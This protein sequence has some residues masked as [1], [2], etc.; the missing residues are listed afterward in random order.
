MRK[1]LVLGLLLL[2]F[3]VH[4]QVTVDNFENTSNNWVAVSCAAEIR[5]NEQ[6]TGLNLSNKVLFAL[7]APGCDNWSGAMLKPC[8]QKGYKYLHAYMYRSNANKP[9]LKVSDTNAKDMEPMTQIVANEWQDVVWDISAYE[10]SGIEFVFFMVDRTDI[11]EDAWMLIDEV[12]LSN[13][14]TPRTAVV[15]G[16]DEP[17]VVNPTGDYQLV[18]QDEFEGTAIDKDMWNIEVDGKGGGNNELQYYCEK[19]VTVGKEPKSGKQCLVLTATKE[20]Y[21]GKHCTSGRVNT[22]NKVYFTHG[23]VEASICFPNTANGL[24]PAFWMMG[25]D[26]AQVGWPRCGETD[27]IEMGNANGIKAG[28]QGMYFNGASHFGTA[29][30]ACEHKAQDHT[31]TYSLQDGEFHLITCV[32]TDE[33]VSMY[34]DLDKN[35]ERAPYYSL[36]LKDNNAANYFH[37]PNFIILNLAVGGD[38]TNIWDINGITALAEGPRAMY[39]D[40]VKVYQ[41]GVA[42]E[43][44][45]GKTTQE[46]GVEEIAGE[47]EDMQVR[48]VM[49]D[50]QLQII[51][52]ENIYTITGQ[53]MR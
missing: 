11:T 27:I 46:T 38:F 36:S 18:W 37:K 6:K 23:K 48:K 2:S 47:K 5:A 16:E 35:P 33:K 39:I 14:A 7:R 49:R 31:A 3:C 12:C 24:W 34:Y 32:W 51:R 4:G 53:K 17:V 21:Q 10:T 40:Y 45:T 42:G 43:T 1:N 41:Q 28:T 19:A 44:F 52:G 22:L 30:D 13:D 20:E 26:F 15:E 9:N 25:N 8:E 29:W 50:G